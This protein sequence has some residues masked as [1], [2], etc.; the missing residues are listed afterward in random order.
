MCCKQ[1]RQTS[2]AAKQHTAHQRKNPK[3][4]TSNSEHITRTKLLTGGNAHLNSFPSYFSSH[5]DFLRRQKSSISMASSPPSLH[6]LHWL[7]LSL[8]TLTDWQHY[9]FTG[10][11]QRLQIDGRKI[12]K[13][14]NAIAQKQKACKQERL[15]GARER[16]QQLLRKAALNYMRPVVKAPPPSLTPHDERTVTFRR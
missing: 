9:I 8:L 2:G 4:R 11:S 10:F 16:P 3:L 12:V 5:R 1:E 13:Y 14:F 6:F 15:Q 7:L